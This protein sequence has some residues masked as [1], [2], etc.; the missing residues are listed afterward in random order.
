MDRLLLCQ[1]MTGVADEKCRE[2][3]IRQEYRHPNEAMQFIRRFSRS[4]SD[5][6]YVSDRPLRHSLGI[7][8]T[9]PA[10]SRQGEPNGRKP[11]S[12]Q[13]RSEPRMDRRN[14]PTTSTRRVSSGGKD[15]R[16][17]GNRQDVPALEWRCDKC[18][19]SHSAATCPL[20]DAACFTCGETS[21]LASRCP[22]GQTTGNRPCPR[23]HNKQNPTS[24]PPDARR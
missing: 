24:P 4:R 12:N 14:R 10:A 21:H 6:V 16:D 8:N 11:K 13:N 23:V 2:E 18:M 22:R 5:S 9:N 7:L 17:R 20:R 1:L 15:G 3:L 19:G